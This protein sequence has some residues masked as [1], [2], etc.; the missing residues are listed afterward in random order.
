MIN[1]YE[2]CICCDDLCCQLKVG[3]YNSKNKHK[4]QQN[5]M[6]NVTK[7]GCIFYDKEKDRILL[8]LTRNNKWGFPKGT[9]EE[10]ETVKQ[11]AIREVKEETGINISIDQ[12]SCSIKIY[13]T[14]YF[15]VEKKSYDVEIQRD[16]PDN[17]V[18]GIGWIKVKC[19]DKLCENNKLKL[20]C[21][22]RIAL[23]KYFKLKNIHNFEKIKKPDNFFFNKKTNCGLQHNKTTNILKVNRL[24]I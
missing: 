23:S 14:V 12:L 13:K 18:N 10:G 24:V 22:S 21:Q 6:R 5:N 15:F 19:I 16:I 20:N 1:N 3:Y 7:A 2:S 17:D 9:I 8:V 4:R 11:C